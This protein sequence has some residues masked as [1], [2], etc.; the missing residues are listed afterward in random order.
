MIKQETA[1]KL[2]EALEDLTRDGFN[3]LTRNKRR[4]K[5]FIAKKV[6][7]QAKEEL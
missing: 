4:I 6:I 1:M 3:E 2:L 5:I 7:K